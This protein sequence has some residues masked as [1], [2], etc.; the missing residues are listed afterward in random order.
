MNNNPRD[1]RRSAARRVLT[2]FCPASFAFEGNEY[3]ALMT[4]LSESGAKFRLD[5]HLRECPMQEDYQIA[6]EIR[7]PY[8]IALVHGTVVWAGHM[9]EHFYF[10][11][12]FRNLSSNPLDPVR[13]LLDST[14]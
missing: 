11:I 7:T 3:R 1:D 12:C 8:G 6:L 13:S 9:D 4:D 5:E 14:F 10:G 2:T